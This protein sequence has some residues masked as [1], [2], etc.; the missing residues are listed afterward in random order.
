M[1]PQSTALVTTLLVGLVY[2]AD[3]FFGHRGAPIAPGLFIQLGV[4]AAV[5][6]VT[7]VLASRV[8]VMGA[9]REALAGELQQVSWKP[10]IVRWKSRT[11]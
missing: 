11:G 7:A 10:T 9:E 4:F 5:A 3:I 6:A 2:F 8:K 1:P